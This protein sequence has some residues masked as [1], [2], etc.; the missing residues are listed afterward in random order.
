MRPMVV[1]CVLLLP[2]SAA[3][4]DEAIRIECDEPRGTREFKLPGS[5]FQSEPE[6]F[7]G[8]QPTFFIRV[9][10]P[11]QLIVHLGP[12]KLLGDVLP[13]TVRKAKIGEMSPER[14]V[15]IERTGD[16]YWLYSFFPREG[17]AYFA[18]HAVMD[19]LGVG[20]AATFHA[21]CTTTTP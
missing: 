13:E 14:I 18:R 15:A 10:D 5:D 1:I 17:V 7:K 21:R 19:G 9:D 4:V 3:A 11:S 20:S 2:L 16:V 12:A 8:V 6:A